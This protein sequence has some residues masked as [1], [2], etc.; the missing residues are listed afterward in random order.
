MF[1][2]TNKQL[3]EWVPWWLTF[4]KHRADVLIAACSA[5][6]SPVSGA[7]QEG[8]GL[9]F[10]L[11]AL[12]APTWAGLKE[13]KAAWGAEL[14]IWGSE[15]CA[16]PGQTF[17]EWEQGHG[18]AV[19]VMAVS[20]ECGLCW[21]E[22]FETHMCSWSPLCHL[23]LPVL[24]PCRG[25]PRQLPGVIPTGLAVRVSSHSPKRTSGI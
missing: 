20:V 3:P 12:G 13:D 5:E 9:M 15:G 1:R 7:F 4:G 24:L 17:R 16:R 10:S 21:T 23:L 8:E 22:H 6:P 19:E 11:R 18:S 14:S 25:A 2:Q